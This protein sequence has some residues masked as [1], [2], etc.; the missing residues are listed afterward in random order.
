MFLSLNEPS[1]EF[2]RPEAGYENPA[3]L[4]LGERERGKY[5]IKSI[6]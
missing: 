6:K 4:P 3:S 2:L 1:G 5:F